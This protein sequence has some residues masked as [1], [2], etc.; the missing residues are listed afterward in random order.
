MPAPRNVLFVTPDFGENSLG[1]TYCLWLLARHLGWGTGVVSAKGNAL[2]HPLAGSEFAADCLPRL[3]ARS[4]RGRVEQLRGTAADFDT[5]VAVKPL[6]ESYGLARSAVDPSSQTFVLDCDDPDLE[7]WQLG[8]LNTRRWILRAG[9]HP[10]Y[11]L[12]MQRMRAAAHREARMITSNPTLQQRHGGSVI[13]HS[14][15]LPAAL[16]PHTASAPSVAFVGTARRHKGI[17]QLR[18]AVSKL[19]SQGYTLTVTDDAPADAMPHERWVGQVSMERGLEIVA[20][21]DISAIPSLDDVFSRGQLPAKLIDAMMSG[22]AIVA[23]SLPPISWALSATGRLV[24]PG[25]TEALVTALSE[26]RS[27]SVRNDLGRA[28]RA[29]AETMFTVEALAPAFERACSPAGR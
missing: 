22:R 10:L 4:R 11:M 3:S 24:P 28:A 2:W 15:P 13:A 5:V 6:P 12:G 19:S 27:P 26:L 25:D 17:D 9:R 21:S 18:H 23:S 1:R 7:A 20:H 8:G 14:R 16:A 29:R